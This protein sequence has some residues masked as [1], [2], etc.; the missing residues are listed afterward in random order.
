MALQQPGLI[1]R[2]EVTTN[3]VITPRMG[4]G[5]RVRRIFV[6]NPSAP[7]QH[8]TVINDTARVGFFRTNGLGGSH[9]LNPR[10][11]EASAAIRGGNVLD[12]MT[13]FENFTGYPVVQGE[14]MTLQLDTG[15]ADIFAVADSYDAADV[16]SSEQCGSKSPDVLFMNYGT[17]GSAVT[18][19]GYT[20]LSLS[21]NPAEMVNFPYGIPGSGL[22]P[23][24][25]KAH[26]YVIGGAAVGRYTSAG[27]TAGTQW[28]RPRLGNVPAM[29]LFDRND[30]GVP[31]IGNVPG[32]AGADYTAPRQAIPSILDASNDWYRVLAQLD[33]N[34]N[35]EFSLQ[36]STTVAGT[37]QLSANDM[38][39]WVLMRVYPAS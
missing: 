39:F 20:K 4:E 33:F 3:L 16:K 10:A 37:G 9:M 5:F 2:A 27:N 31:V 11:H 6:A 24:G 15:T 26:I 29:T 30:V 28:L 19:A 12:W 34:G 32:A 8:L 1:Y 17:N 35:D 21:R 25:K 7:I 18:S 22:V 13:K 38:D 36:V 14:A 23:A